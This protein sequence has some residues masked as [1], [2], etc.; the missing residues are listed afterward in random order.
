MKKTITFIVVTIVMFFILTLFACESAPTYDY[1]DEYAKMEQELSKVS[2]DLW[3]LQ[4]EY[5]QKEDEL[6]YLQSDYD[7]QK[8]ERDF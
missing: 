6:I 8:A 3:D 4:Q 1:Y 5:E 2:G 7:D